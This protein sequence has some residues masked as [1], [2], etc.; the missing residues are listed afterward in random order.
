MFGQ[1]RDHVNQIYGWL[2]SLQDQLA[3]AKSPDARPPGDARF[4]QAL[5]EASL[6]AGSPILFGVITDATPY[7]HVYRVQVGRNLPPLRC[8][9]GAL[10]DFGP[11]G[12]RPLTTLPPGTQVI[13]YKEE[14]A[15]SGV[16]LAA[17]PN[18]AYDAADQLCTHIAHATRNRVDQANRVPARLNPEELLSFTSGRPFDST[19][20]GEWGYI[21]PFGPRIHLD[22]FLVQVGINERC[23]LFFHWHDA[24]VRL[25][26]YNFRHFTAGSERVS[27]N[28]QGELH[29]WEGY[30][31]YPWEQLGLYNPGEP[32]R[33]FSAEEWQLKQPYYGPL[34]P[35]DDAQRPWHRLRTFRGYLGQGQTQVVELP[36]EGETVAKFGEE[37]PFCPAVAVYRLGHDGTVV[38]TSGK[39]TLVGRHP[40]LV[41][42]QQKSPP[43]Q[44]TGS[45]DDES[46]YLFSGRFGSGKPHG[47][48]P[49]SL[50]EPYQRILALLDLNACVFNFSLWSPF[51]FHEKD[52]QVPDASDQQV[53]GWEVP[54]YSK[55]K[56]EPL[57][58]P[59]DPESKTV[60]HRGSVDLYPNGC[61]TVYDDDG[62]VTTVDGWGSAIVMHGGKIF[63]HAPHGVE[64][65]AGRTVH[66]EA[67]EDVV[68]TAKD[69][70]DI[71]AS[72]K[73]VR[74]KAEKGM[75]LLGG[76]SGQGGV[77][78]ESRGTDQ[79]QLDN[80]GEDSIAGGIV[81]RS[82]EGTLNLVGKELYLRTTDSG[83]ITLDADKGSGELVANLSAAT[84]LTGHQGLTVAYGTAGQHLRA[85]TVL[86][87]RETLLAGS[88]YVRGTL[89]VRDSISGESLSLLGSIAV[90]SGQEHLS[91]IRDIS[92]LQAIIDAADEL[93][94]TLDA[95]R[96]RYE[97]Y[98]EKFLQEERIG[99]EETLEKLKFSLRTEEQYGTEQ[100]VRLQPVWTTMAEAAG[101]SLASWEEKA[102]KG[103]K[104]VETYPYPGKKHYQ[105]PG[106]LAVQTLSLVQ[107][108]AI[109]RPVP[110][111]A[112]STSPADNY[113]YPKLEPIQFKSLNERKV[114]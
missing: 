6:E 103:P 18:V 58:P 32:Y 15:N 86:G 1:L 99:H 61:F 114:P 70:V 80:P 56:T 10:G 51:I 7:G 65:L 77:L 104:D 24:F 112:T 98:Q 28:D 93:P 30:A 106:A 54:D 20:I 74:L 87:E 37:Q 94:K 36:P 17:I 48:N 108:Q 33:Q 49:P 27:L 84:L 75:W 45:G 52:W 3:E 50:E 57:L 13:V 55:V 67:G 43:E 73:D 25:A 82:S 91:Q 89:V 62:T 53:A 109:L 79:F 35:Y 72:E 11:I 101:Q 63:L 92:L 21:S 107:G 102:V 26:A 38:I 39:R 34:E 90:G 41:S 59:P 81:F 16:I 46:N 110:R 42:P 22:P 60:D 14:G 111:E 96:S 97:Q 19:M 76:N 44:L 31:L 105:E 64:L 5:R 78:I 66:V 71:V 83:N 40:W 88:T 4:L 8:V 69:S 12:V 68:V 95:P 2:R 47:S 113:A 85:R 29:E 9:L 23:G 100:Y